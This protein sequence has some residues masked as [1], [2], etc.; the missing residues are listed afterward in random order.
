MT[1]GA[2]DSPY[3]FYVAPQPYAFPDL[4]KELYLSDTGPVSAA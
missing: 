3:L 1:N 2:H 4:S